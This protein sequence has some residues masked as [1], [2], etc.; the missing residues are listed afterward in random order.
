[1]SSFTLGQAFGA[2]VGTIVLSIII[3]VLLVTLVSDDQ[4][5]TVTMITPGRFNNSG[6]GRTQ[7]PDAKEEEQDMDDEFDF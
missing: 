4:P 7:E 2:V 5:V 1:M 3:V 6:L